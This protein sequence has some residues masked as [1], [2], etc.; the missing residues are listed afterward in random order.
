MLKKR[1]NE[2][3]IKFDIEKKSKGASKI[4]N[5]LDK[6]KPSILET[7]QSSLG[8]LGEEAVALQVQQNSTKDNQKLGVL[9]IIACFFC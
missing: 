6:S 1:M 4:H 2:I 9:V 5:D 8:K 3:E 7:A